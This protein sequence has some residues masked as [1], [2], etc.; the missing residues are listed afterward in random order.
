MTH[1]SVPPERRAK[2]GITEG[3]I[4]LSVGVEDV[5]DLLTD[6]DHAIS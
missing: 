3:L 5:A 4:R 1:A 2:I 6:L